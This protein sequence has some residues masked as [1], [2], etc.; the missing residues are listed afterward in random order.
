MNAAT[1]HRSRTRWWMPPLVIPRYLPSPSFAVCS[2]LVPPRLG[3]RYYQSI[4]T[5]KILKDTFEKFHI[6]GQYFFQYFYILGWYRLIFFLIFWS[7]GSIS[8]YFSQYSYPR[9][10]S[11]NTFSDLLILGWYLPIL[12]PIFWSQ[13]QYFFTFSKGWIGI[14]LKNWLAPGIIRQNCSKY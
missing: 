12:F 13:A 5:I 9:P 8:R 7:R 6:V 2:H 3:S 1:L 14:K 11:S 10:V 4:D